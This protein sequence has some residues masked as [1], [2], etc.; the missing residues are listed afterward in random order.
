MTVVKV[1][2]FLNSNEFFAGRLDLMSNQCLYMTSLLALP[3]AVLTHIS[4]YLSW[5][6]ALCNLGLVLPVWY[7]L[8]FDQ[9]LLQSQ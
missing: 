9:D 4:T 2:D 8:H 5:S 6:H 3:D 1:F 7:V